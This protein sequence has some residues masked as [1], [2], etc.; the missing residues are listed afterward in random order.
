[1]SS[2]LR[3]LQK[4][5]NSHKKAQKGTKKRPKRMLW[6]RCGARASRPAFSCAEPCKQPS[7]QRAPSEGSRKSLRKTDLTQ[8]RKDAKTQRG[9]IQRHWASA[10]PIRG[11]RQVG[12]WL[13]KR[14]FLPLCQP[15]GAGFA[16]IR[17]TNQPASRLPRVGRP[18]IESPVAR[19]ACRG[20]GRRT[21]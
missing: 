13:G 4:Q 1:M 8:R 10:D 9:V 21:T 3:R 14:A 11:P 19:E 6:S 5:G 17:R 16:R 12:A 2:Q 18:S 20:G 7:S 15:F